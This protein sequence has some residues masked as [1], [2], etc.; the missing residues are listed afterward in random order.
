MSLRKTQAI[1]FALMG[2]WDNAISLNQTL[3]H[4]NPNDID[5]LNRLAFALASL[6]NIKEAKQMYQKVLSLDTQN[7]IAMKNLKRLTGGASIKK[8][9]IT[10]G[11]P[12]SNIFIEE[13]GKTKVTDLINIADKRII[14]QLRPGE[15]LQL[16]VKRMKIFVLDSEKQYVGMLADDMSRR[17]IK[18]I[19]GGNK[20]I[21][22]IKTLAGNKVTIF[23]KEEKRAKRFAH[24]PTF[25]YTA[26]TNTAKAQFDGKKS[27]PESEDYSP[28]N[29]EESF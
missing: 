9:Q 18:F 2:D 14:G 1:Q 22:Y 11:L 16:C 26:K 27:R 24:Q 12:V 20:Y 8:P 17:L 23:V 4:E 28:E 10:Q 29:E 15:I 3:L 5:T 13:P 7:P 19:N 21:A 25:L 6:G